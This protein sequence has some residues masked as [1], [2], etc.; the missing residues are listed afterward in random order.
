MVKV[1]QMKKTS[2]QSLRKSMNSSTRFSTKIASHMHARTVSC[3]VPSVPTAP[4][5][6]ALRETIAC[7]S[8]PKSE[9]TLIH[10]SKAM[11][12]GRPMPLC[13]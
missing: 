7:S 6:P 2:T 4:P 3:R 13:A 1:F 8:T 5:A 10:T 11:N 12:S 9:P